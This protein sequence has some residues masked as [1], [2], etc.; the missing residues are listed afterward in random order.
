MGIKSW[1]FLGINLSSP[2][3]FVLVYCDRDSG[4]F[5]VFK[6][7]TPGFSVSSALL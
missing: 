6:F 1:N 3:K 5:Q 2:S 4:S 7:G